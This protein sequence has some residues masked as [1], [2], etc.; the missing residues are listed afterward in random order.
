MISYERFMKHI[1]FKY[2][3]KIK[4]ADVYVDDLRRLRRTLFGGVEAHVYAIGDVILLE[5]DGVSVKKPW[6]L[7]HGSDDFSKLWNTDDE[8]RFCQDIMDIHQLI[9]K[10]RDYFN[11]YP[12]NVRRYAYIEILAQ[13]DK[14]NDP[15]VFDAW[16][17]KQLELGKTVKE[18]NDD[19]VFRRINVDI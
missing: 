8:S 1:Q 10:N 18:I 16:Y 3:G 14:L 13:T 2:K 6:G 4:E 12:D 9:V 17:D 11:K 19:I 7:F 5:V 15:I